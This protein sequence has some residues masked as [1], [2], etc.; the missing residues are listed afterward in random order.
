[1]TEKD[2]FGRAIKTV[3]DVLNSLLENEIDADRR[4]PFDICLQRIHDLEFAENSDE[5][6]VA[7]QRLSRYVDDCVPWTDELLLSIERLNTAVRT[8]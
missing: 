3:K 5:R 6:L 7:I 2:P 4:R 8:K 1:M